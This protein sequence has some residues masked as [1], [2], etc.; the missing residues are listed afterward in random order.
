MVRDVYKVLWESRNTHI[1]Y[2]YNVIEEILFELQR[3]PQVTRKV[4]LGT[5]ATTA[6]QEQVSL[7][8]DGPSSDLGRPG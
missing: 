7:M 6:E 1:K 3:E 4:R 5:P 8:K 2:A